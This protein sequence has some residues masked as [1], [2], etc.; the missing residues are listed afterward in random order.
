MAGL[1]AVGLPLFGGLLVPSPDLLLVGL[2]DAVGRSGFGLT[3]P[4]AVGPGLSLWFQ[5]WCLDAGAVQGFSATSAQR[6][7]NS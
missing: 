1:S 5:S 2:T 4:T 7:S 6:V 3:I